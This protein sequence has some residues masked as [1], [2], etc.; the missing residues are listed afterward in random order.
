MAINAERLAPH[1]YAVMRIVFGAMFITYGLQK[2]G[3]LGG[4]AVP[5][6]GRMGVAALIETL[7]GLL[8]AIGFFTRSAAFIASGQ[9]AAAY[10]MSHHP[11]GLL[12]VHNQGIP[13]VLFCFAFLYFAAHGAGIWSVDGKRGRNRRRVRPLP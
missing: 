7:G 2:L 4:Q 10:F 1:A 5:L 13:A 9:M 3:M 11:R 6:A 12:P 8:I